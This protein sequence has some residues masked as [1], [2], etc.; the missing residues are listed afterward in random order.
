M[1]DKRLSL[2]EAIAEYVHDGMSVAIEGFTAF[3]CFAAGHEIMRQ[4][5]RDL[6]IEQ[7]SRLLSGPELAQ[8][9]FLAARVDHHQG[10]GI[11]DQLPESVERTGGERVDE[12]ESLVRG[13]LH[14]AQA[15]MVGVLADELGVEPESAGGC[16]IVA[17]R[18]QFLGPGDDLFDHRGGS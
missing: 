14:Q 2:Q 8:A 3:I 6:Q 16:Q 1:M 18:R 17:A 5:R 9:H 11:H 15:R 13:D 12:K 4:G 7:V 10:R